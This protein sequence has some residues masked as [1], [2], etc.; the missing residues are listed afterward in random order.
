M[1]EPLYNLKSEQTIPPHPEPD[2]HVHVRQTTCIGG[3][4]KTTV[5]F[6]E[7]W[8]PAGMQLVKSIGC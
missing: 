7:S 8:S 3:F 2:L 5:N 6:Q 4:K 1:I